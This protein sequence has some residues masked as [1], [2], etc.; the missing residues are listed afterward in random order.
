MPSPRMDTA[1]WCGPQG[2][3]RI[4]MNSEALSSGSHGGL[5]CASLLALIQQ[6]VDDQ[7]MAKKVTDARTHI[8][9]MEYTIENFDK[10][11]NRYKS[12]LS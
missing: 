6:D 4:S 8:A 5:S 3:A 10:T 7:E 11:V 2:H 1:G 9:S 12:I